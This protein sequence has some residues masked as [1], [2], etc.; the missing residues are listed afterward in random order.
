MNHLQYLLFFK[1]FMN[2]IG[3]LHH[4]QNELQH[5]KYQTSAVHLAFYII[6]YFSHFA[7]ALIQSDFLLW[8]VLV[9]RG[10]QTH[11]PGVAIAMLYQLALPATWDLPPSLK[12]TATKEWSNLD[13]TSVHNLTSVMLADW[14]VMSRFHGER[15]ECY[16]PITHTH[17]KKKWVDSCSGWVLCVLLMPLNQD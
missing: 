4:T 14:L 17:T 15:L 13:P 10:N 8:L 16:F 12:F 11:N 3:L 1:R 9:L 5:L 6:W 2:K 7:D